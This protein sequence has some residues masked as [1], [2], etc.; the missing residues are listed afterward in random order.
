VSVNDVKFRIKL[1]Y[2]HAMFLSLSAIVNFILAALIVFRLV[3]YRRCARNA[4][5]VEHGTSYNNV[6]IMCVE[7]SALMV[8]ASGL[9]TILYFKSPRIGEMFMFEVVLHIYVGGLELDDF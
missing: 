6:I 5:G 9:Y 7:S 4:L 3:Y 2:A 8:I 1:V